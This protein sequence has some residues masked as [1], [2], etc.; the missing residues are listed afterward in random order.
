MQ[1]EAAL[2]Q[3]LGPVPSLAGECVLIFGGTSGIGL[4]TA[5]AAKAA[6]AAVTIAGRDRD[7]AA[8]VARTH[9]FADSFAAEISD[10]DAIRQGLSAIDRVDHLVILA[11]SL[12]IGKIME[13]EIGLLE[14]AYD[15]RI[16]SVVHILRTLGE[17]LAT[18]ASITLVSGALTHRPDGN[19]TAIIASA[20]AA[21]EVLG[22]GLALELAPRRVNTLSP[23]PIDTPLI[24]KAMGDQRDAY[25]RTVAE[26]HPLHRWGSAQEAATAVLF[27]MTNR[28]MNGE[29]LHIDGGSRL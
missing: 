18:D 21:L 10:P 12:T 26:S 27:L 4:A 2:A 28:Y 14:R 25:M 9:G 3:A 6:G 22:R 1:K 13:A 19:G 7:R 29:V 20:C 15:E 23:G 5:V 24:G 16:W 17:R 8:D 11:G